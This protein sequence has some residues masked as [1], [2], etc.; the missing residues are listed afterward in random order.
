MYC[1]IFSTGNFSHKSVG[2]AKVLIWLS[3]KPTH[4]IWI[5][6]VRCWRLWRNV[7]EIWY[8]AAKHLQVNGV[9]VCILNVTLLLKVK[10]WQTDIT[11]HCQKWQL[12]EKHTSSPVALRRWRRLNITVQRREEVCR[13]GGDGKSEE[14]TWIRVD[15]KWCTIIF[16][17]A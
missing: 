4:V 10:W 11:Y 3:S 13:G 7:L 14:D 6:N 2:I 15:K 17:A 5:W 9:R 1:I 12:S 16:R 8:S